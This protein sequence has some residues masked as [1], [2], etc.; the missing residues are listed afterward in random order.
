MKRKLIGPFQEMVTMSGM[1][2]KGPLQDVDLSVLQEG[3]IVI[4]RDQIVE[5]GGFQQLR[6]KHT[7]PDVEFIWQAPGSIALPGYIDCHTHIAFGGAR[8]AD[9]AM[10]NAGCTYLDIAE[11]GG[12]IWST[13]RDT[14]ASDEAILV[15]WTIRRAFN[16]LKQGVT[17]IEVKSGYGLT[18]KE[19]LKMLRAIQ[20][21][22]RECV[23][24][25][26]PTC[27]AAHMLPH[28]F[29]ESAAIYLQQLVDELF[30]VLKEEK[31]SSRIDAFVEKGAFSADT[32][33]PYLCQA[34]D[35]G[36]DLTLHADQFTVSGT[37]LAVELQAK[38]ADHLEASGTEEIAYLA[39]SDTV[40]VALPAASLG[41]GCAFAPARALLDRGACLAIATDW[42][43]GS[44]PMGNLMTSA[45]ILAAREKLSNAELFAAI[46]YRAAHALGLED[47]GRIEAGMKADLVIYN[48]ESY[49]YISYLQGS[50]MPVAVWKNGQEAF[51]NTQANADR[52]I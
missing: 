15:E 29:K 1:P 39:A 48:V 8:A 51:R 35:Q 2:L 21:A 32:I 36:F 16:L 14:R 31:L 40:A 3:G 13:V 6:G 47:R 11:A 9:F 12:G 46:T 34:K 24:D 5:V 41:L 18:V 22:D 27:L 42:N 49:P 10:R 20:R 26:V 25:L 7:G 19:E 33:R 30:P 45:S 50:V 43:P 38:S 28:D 44:A 52:P 37:A 4:E 17:T 23:S